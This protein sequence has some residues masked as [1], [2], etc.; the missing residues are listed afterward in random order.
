MESSDNTQ[1]CVGQCTSFLRTPKGIVLALEIGLCIVIL[2][3]YGASVRPG[4]TGLAIFEMV[5]SIAFFIVFTLG[6]NKQLAFVHWGWSDFLRAVIAAL[7][8]LITSLIVVIGHS[9]GPATAAGV[10]QLWLSWQS[11]LGA[12]WHCGVGNLVGHALPWQSG[13]CCRKQVLCPPVSAGCSMYGIHSLQSAAMPDN[14]GG[15]MTMLG[16][17]EMRQTIKLAGGSSAPLDP[18]HRAHHNLGS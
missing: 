18:R 3:C 15:C 5:F 17:E 12:G 11:G 4:Y 13:P 7:L 9:D 2:I 1:G 14:R 16:G 6:L 10:K 8:F